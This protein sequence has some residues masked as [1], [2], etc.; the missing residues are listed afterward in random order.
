MVLHAVICSFFVA[1]LWVRQA[2]V[3][4]ICLALWLLAISNE[5]P[6]EDFQGVEELD[7]GA[8]GHP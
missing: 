2:V 5:R 3:E 8:F 6:A 7:S 1:H 4:Y